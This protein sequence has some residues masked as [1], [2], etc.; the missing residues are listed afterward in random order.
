LVVPA[1]TCEKAHCSFWQQ[2]D[3]ASIMTAD[4]PRDAQ[5]AAMNVRHR[6]KQVLSPVA[7]IAA[8]V[9]FL[10]DAVFLSIIRPVGE[11]IGKLPIFDSVREWLASLGP[12]PTLALFVV[13]LVVLEPVKPV[14]AY[15]IATG[16]IFSGV[17]LIVIGEVLKITI[18]ER[19]FH[20]SKDKLMTIAAFAWGYNWLLARLNYLK[21]Q[22]L[23]QAAS[24]KL[25]SLKDAARRL[26]RRFRTSR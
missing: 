8:I 7:A 2:E 21:A 22:P 4:I 12:Y 16:H 20:F 19:L 23:W 14:G 9:Y 6:A 24:K 3:G 26:V 11:A 17:S 18:V 10:I 15:L 13:P 1:G 25:A 5:T